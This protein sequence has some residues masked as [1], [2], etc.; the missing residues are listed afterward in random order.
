[1]DSFTVERDGMEIAAHAVKRG[2]TAELFYVKEYGDAREPFTV[3]Y[4][5]ATGWESGI[6]DYRVKAH[7]VAVALALS[8]LARKLLAEQPAPA[9]SREAVERLA[10]HGLYGQFQPVAL[11]GS[12]AAMF[13]AGPMGT[14][15]PWPE[16]K[17]APA[18]SSTWPRPWHKASPAD[19][20][21]AKKFKADDTPAALF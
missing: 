1:M 14:D 21:I 17:P 7:A 5:N 16:A 18:T 11:T 2:I 9:A 20:K 4:K 15:A 19:A 6:Y 8:D 13:D 3:T 12:Q 10:T